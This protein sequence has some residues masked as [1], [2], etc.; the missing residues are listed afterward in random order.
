[1]T[2]EF[3]IY[4]DKKNE[5]LEKI[6]KAQGDLKALQLESHM[7]TA[8]ASLETLAEYSRARSNGFS[9]YN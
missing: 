6:N 4:A 8:E 1:M 3:Y 9:L 5:L 7:L 2:R